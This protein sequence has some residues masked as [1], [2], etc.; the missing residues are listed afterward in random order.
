VRYDVV[1]LD[2]DGTL[3]DPYEGIT[4]SYRHV[5]ALAGYPVADDV[6][7]GWV[8]GPGVWTNLDRLGVPASEADAVAAAYRERHLAV[9]LYQ[10]VMI[11][12]LEL[13]VAD[14]DRAGVRLALATAKPEGQGVAT[15]LHFGLDQYFTV[16]GGTPEGIRTTK[17]EV[18]ADVLARLG[19]C[20]RDRTVMV[21]DRRHDIEGAHEN[22]L[23]AVGVG[24]G[25]AADGE[26]EAAGADHVVTTVAELRELLLG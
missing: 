14:L 17:G 25:F 21:G 5:L 15:L 1:L 3:T 9:G 23:A 2:L 26:L 19:D 18:V 4:G 10:A 7:L 11:P 13:L 6:D 24:W 20:D 12:G 8:I 22:G 16:M